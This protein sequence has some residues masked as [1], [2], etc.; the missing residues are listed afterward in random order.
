MAAHKIR[1]EMGFNHILDFESLAFGLLYVLVN[2]SLR[3]NDRRFTFRPNQV[4]SMTKTPR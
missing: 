2:I 3:V 1:V 4:R